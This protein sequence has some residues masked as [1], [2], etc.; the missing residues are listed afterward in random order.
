MP[1]LFITELARL[2]S[3][4][5]LCVV[6]GIVGFL[7]VEGGYRVNLLLKDSRLQ[8]RPETI[9]ELPLLGVYNRSIWQFDLAEG[10]QYTDR[11]IF[12]T[13]I[14]NGRID[15]CVLLP[16]DS[17]GSPRVAEASYNDADVKLAV[18]GDSFSL[19]RDASNNTWVS[20]L[21]RVLQDRL[22]RSVHILNLARDGMGLVQMFDIAAIR[23]PRHKPDLAIIA[24]ASVNIGRPRIWRIEKIIDGELRVLTTFEPTENPDLN[25][26]YESHILHPEAENDW[27][28]AHR[29]GGPLDR[30]GFEMIDKYLRFRPPRYSVFTPYRSFLWHKIVHRNPFYSNSDRSFGSGVSPSGMAMDQKLLSSIETLN[31]SGVPYI[32][33]HLPSY[34]EISTGEEYE[35]P[36]M[37]KIAQET[38]RLTGQPVRGLLDYMP[39][40]IT[41]RERMTHSVEDLHPSAL[42][43]QMYA[44]AVANIVLGGGF[45][46]EASRP[47]GKD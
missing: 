1:R 40:P 32:L 45:K 6:A 22:G 11:Q 28:A 33:I 26:S 14:E 2:R 21:Q 25:S 47:V 12:Q 23:I 16:R 10:F 3:S 34:R 39:L 37:A 36:V 17:Y 43:M 15:N 35:L 18:F 4:L 9:A 38:S 24:V 27:C 13:T 20:Y 5:I 44:E 46:T 19:S 41:N 30:I 31:R 42:G 29:N 8:L 7:L